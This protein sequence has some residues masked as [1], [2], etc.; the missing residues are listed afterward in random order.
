MKLWAALTSASAF[1]TLVLA[2]DAPI[3][4]ANVAA[5]LVVRDRFIVKY[6]DGTGASAKTAHENT[7]NTQSKSAN[8]KGVIAKINLSGLEG[9]VVDLDADGLKQLRSSGIVEYLEKDTV[10]NA[11]DLEQ[12]A[13]AN[14]KLRRAAVT[15]NSAPWNLGRISHKEKGSSDY[16]YDSTAGVGARVYVIGTGVLITHTEFNG[17]ASYGANFVPGSPNTDELGYGTSVASIVGGRTVGVA[18]RAT[19]ISVKVLDKNGGGSISGIIQAINWIVADAVSRGVARKSVIAMMAGGSY[20]AALNAA[21]LASTNAGLTFVAGS[22]S[23]D[24]DANGF[25]P[26][27]APTCL[28][29]AAIDGLD[30]RTAASNW[31]QSVDIFAPGMTILSAYIGSNTAMRYLT[32]TTM[33]APHVAGLAAYFIAKENL[34]GHP[35]V[36][37]RILSVAV[38]GKVVDPKGSNNRIAYNGSGK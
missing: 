34:N 32:G 20:S 15:Q 23:S 38:T 19:I 14:E 7:I 12:S 4:N 5:D 17:R 28:T 27:S 16:V 31:G 8:K 35:A 22:G 33:A 29:V 9:Y 18:K 24:S 3:T 13:A 11:T 30:R 37:N 36:S 1:I 10:V 2:A 26:A 21:V 6:K 25:S